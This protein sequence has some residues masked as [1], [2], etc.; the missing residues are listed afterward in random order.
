MNETYHMNANSRVCSSAFTWASCTYILL[1]YPT[2]F[3]LTLLGQND[4]I[5]TRL[6]FTSYQ[7]SS[8]SFFFYSFTAVERLFGCFC[9]LRSNS[10]L[11]ALPLLLDPPMYLKVSTVYAT[12]HSTEGQLNAILWFY[13]SASSTALL[14]SCM[15][16]TSTIHK[17]YSMPAVVHA[18]VSGVSSLLLPGSYVPWLMVKLCSASVP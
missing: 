2:L 18:L 4:V 10:G 12:A 16:C 5:L 8:F 14:S 6:P 1:L 17:Q 15:Y 9:S 7:L 11:I 13:T 3:H